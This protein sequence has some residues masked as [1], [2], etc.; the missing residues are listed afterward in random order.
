MHIETLT[1]QDMVYK[2]FAP[3]LLKYVDELT[4]SVIAK[5]QIGITSGTSTIESTITKLSDLYE[6]VILATDKLGEDTKKAEAIADA[7]EQATFYHDVVIADMEEVRG[8]A[9]AAEPMIPEG[10]LPYPT[11][12]Q[13]LFY[14]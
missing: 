2:Q 3:A 13:M 14:V 11:Y 9:D 7:Q 4:A 12:E 5:K 8:Y 1:L 6:K 10:Y